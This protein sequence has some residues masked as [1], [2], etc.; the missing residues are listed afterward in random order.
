MSQSVLGHRTWIGFLSRY[1]LKSCLLR[2]YRFFDLD[3]WKTGSWWVRLSWVLEHVKGEGNELTHTCVRINSWL[4]KAQLQMEV[5]VPLEKVFVVI[6]HGRA[7]TD[8]K[9]ASTQMSAKQVLCLVRLSW[10]QE[11]E[12]LMGNELYECAMIN[13]WSVTLWVHTYVL[14]PSGL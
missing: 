3:I 8:T 14:L 4:A 11:D 2:P 13:T 9:S 10:V 12:K 5:V 7:L 1:K 6:S